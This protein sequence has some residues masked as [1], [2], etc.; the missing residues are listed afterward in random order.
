M[1]ELNLVSEQKYRDHDQVDQ[2]KNGF[3]RDDPPINK[4]LRWDDQ[5]ENAWT[6]KKRLALIDASVTRIDLLCTIKE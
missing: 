1:E 4:R 5:V 3:T 6:V 2:D